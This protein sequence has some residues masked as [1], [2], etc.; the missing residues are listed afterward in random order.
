MGVS[1]GDDLLAEKHMKKIV[2][3]TYRLATKMKVALTYMDE[4]MLRELMASI[5]RP[6]LE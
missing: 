5:I 6:R 3:A 2:G 1:I 4:E